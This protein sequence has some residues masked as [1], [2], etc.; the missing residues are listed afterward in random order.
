MDLNSHCSLLIGRPFSHLWYWGSICTLLGK[1]HMCD[2]IILFLGLKIMM[3]CYTKQLSTEWY[4]IAKGVQMIGGRLL[5]K[6]YYDVCIIFYSYGKIIHWLSTF[7]STKRFLKHHKKAWYLPRKL[8]S[9]CPDSPENWWVW[10]LYQFTFPMS[11][12]VAWTLCFQVV[13]LYGDSWILL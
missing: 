5:G 1:I 12:T 11:T 4:K 2:I 9:F 7:Y 10:D 6:S 13:F 3:V 8:V